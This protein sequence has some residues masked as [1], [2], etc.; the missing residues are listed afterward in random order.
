MKT[1]KEELKEAFPEVAYIVLFAFVAAF[2]IHQAARNLS[3]LFSF[4]G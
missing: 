2:L 4:D 3:F 1:L